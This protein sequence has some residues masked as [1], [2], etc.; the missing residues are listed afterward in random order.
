MKRQITWYASAGVAIAATCGVIVHYATTGGAEHERYCVEYVARGDLTVTISASGTLEPEEVVDVGARV[1]GQIVSF[2]KDASG[3]PVDYG[4]VVEKEALLAR[5][6][7]ELYRA[8]VISAEAAVSSASAG[9]QRAEADL[10]QMRAKLR[11]AERDWERAQKLV[12]TGIITETSFDACRSAF[13]VCQANVAVDMAAILQAQANLAQSGTELARARRNLGY[14]TIASPVK[15]VVIDRRVNIGQ[16]VVSSMEAPSLF[17]IA[18]DLTRMQIWVA[19]NEADI[20]RIR[21]GQHVSFTVDAFPDRVFEGAVG[22]V[23]LNATMSQNVVTYTVVITTGNPKGLLLPYLTANVRFEVAQSTNALRVPC[24]ALRWQ[25][26]IA[27]VAPADRAR[28]ADFIGEQTAT[29]GGASATIWTVAGEFV[30]PLRVHPGLTDGS[31]TE[32]DGMGIKEGLEVV[33][34]ME[35]ASAAA[36]TTRNPFIPNMPKPPSG[37][38]RPPM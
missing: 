35:T 12:K 22:A 38:S 13:E 19:V 9:V 14:C 26:T 29:N 20:G 37:A 1:S 27:Q 4:S 18:K 8:D 23:R 11:Q 30:R 36:G 3:K 31:F 24:A 10:L 28:A 5:I 25:P 2:G 15:G 17:L 6:D 33:A 34:G 21:P 32:V 7:D 16:T